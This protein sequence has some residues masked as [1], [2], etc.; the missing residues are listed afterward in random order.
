MR[1][2]DGLYASFNDVFI[3]PQF[4]KSTSRT[5]IDISSRIGPIVLKTPVISANMP[6]ITGVDMAI[7]MAKQGALG[8][9]PRFNS[10]E[11]A[12]RD[13]EEVASKTC[14]LVGVSIGVQHHD[15]DRFK[16]LYDAGARL[17]CID[18]AHGH[19]QLMADILSWIR[20]TY[21]CYPNTSTWNGDS[22]SKAPI[23]IGGNVA[24]SSG[25]L[26]LSSWGCDIVKV[27]I[28]PGSA[29][30]TR[31]NTGV[32][33]PQFGAL[34]N[35][36]KNCPSIPIIADGGIKYTGDIPKALIF[37]NAVMLAKMLSGTAETP[38]CVFEDEDGT[39]YKRFGG[40]ASGENKVSHAAANRFVEGHMMNIPFRG[41]VKYII[42]KIRD[43]VQ[44]A[45][46]YSGSESMDE[47]HEKVIYGMMTMS[48]SIESKLI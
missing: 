36:H 10:D 44:T 14:G 31:K 4:S 19:H 23:I 22:S 6:S 7:E 3:A 24:S 17:F 37:S 29:C 2:L 20:E 11:D 27:G 45:F 25:V 16:R 48:G 1:K 47:Y 42:H 18:V 38:G 8:I 15:K 34:E 32:G 35:I 30:L 46:S 13:Y 21:G 26:A 43:A 40:S 33:V 9:L 39:F 5:N 12:V 28:G 41:K